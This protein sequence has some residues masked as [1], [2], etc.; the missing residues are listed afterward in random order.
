MLERLWA[1]VRPCGIVCRT[2][3]RDRYFFT[4]PVMRWRQD[5]GLPFLIPVVMRGRNPKPGTKARGLRGCR[6]RKAGSYPYT[7]R[8]GTDAVD[9][10]LVVTYQSYRHH[11]T[12]TRG[13][14]KMFFAAW[15]VR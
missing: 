10:R 12:K 2:A 8:A 5:H 15:K 14:K 1:Q 4:V 9:F 7:H 11:R 13:T 3:L 6:D